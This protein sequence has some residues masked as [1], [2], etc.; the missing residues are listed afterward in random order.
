[1]RRFFADTFY[2][3]ALLVRSDAWHTRVTAFNHTLQCA[4]IL[5]TTDAVI[6]EFLAAF[7]SAGSYMRQ[8]AVARVEGMLTNPYMRVVEVTRA[9]A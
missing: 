2:W 9:A 8:Q 1:M 3:I 5:F 4:D 6:L 7:S